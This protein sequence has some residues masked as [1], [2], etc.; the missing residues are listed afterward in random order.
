LELSSRPSELEKLV[1]R[2]NVSTK[3]G[4]SAHAMQLRES[5]LPFKDNVKDRTV[6][7]VAALIE[8][9]TVF[10]FIRFDESAHRETD[11]AG[12]SDFVDLK[13][14]TKRPTKL[15]IFGNMWPIDRL[16]DVE[17][18]LEKRLY[19]NDIQLLVHVAKKVGFKRELFRFLSWLKLVH[20]SRD[21]NGRVHSVL[22]RHWRSRVQV[23]RPP[24]NS[25]E[26]HGPFQDR[27]EHVRV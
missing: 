24:A 3:L 14:H 8:K 17:L 6:L 25:A 21:A 16:L 22:Y 20:F 23:L 13:W 5:V 7:M 1:K 19:L 12:D 2:Q 15:H 11:S 26:E 4:S 18:H 9:K 27:S 10:S